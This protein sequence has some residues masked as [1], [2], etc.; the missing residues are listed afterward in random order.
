M[1][2]LFASRWHPQRHL[3]SLSHQNSLFIIS[4]VFWLLSLDE[5]ATL[6]CH[7]FHQLIPMPIVISAKCVLVGFVYIYL[8]YILFDVKIS[9]ISRQEAQKYLRAFLVMTTLG[10]GCALIFHMHYFARRIHSAEFLCSVV[11][12]ILLCRLFI[13][14]NCAI[15]FYLIWNGVG[16]LHTHTTISNEDFEDFLAYYDMNREC[17]DQRLT[18][19]CVCLA[20]Q[21]KTNHN[22]DQLNEDNFSI[23]TVK[24]WRK[25]CFAV[26]GTIIFSVA[27]SA[28]ICHLCFT[29]IW[30][31]KYYPKDMS[32]KTHNESQFDTHS[33][34]YI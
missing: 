21:A 4:V 20:C 11:Y 6:I 10:I 9:A 13:S 16:N 30:S 23:R 29:S 12:S 27:F 32:G 1:G 2:I 22:V 33:I 14:I 25:S 3:F 24:E 5:L 28:E 34:L 17:T 31:H 8:L 26:A 18:L 7:Y 15:V 19:N